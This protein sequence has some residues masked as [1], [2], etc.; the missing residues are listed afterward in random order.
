MSVSFQNNVVMMLFGLNNSNGKNNGEKEPLVTRSNDDN[1]DSRKKYICRSS[2]F[3]STESKGSIHEEFYGDLKSASK[4]GSQCSKAR[5][6]NIKSCENPFSTQGRSH[7]L[8]IT[9]SLRNIQGKISVEREN[10]LLLQRDLSANCEK[11]WYDAENLYLQMFS[12][13]GRLI[14]PHSYITFYICTLFGHN[15]QM[16]FHTSILSF[17][18]ELSVICCS[19]HLPPLSI[20]GVFD[21]KENICWIFFN[22]GQPNE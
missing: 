18:D 22:R 10:K 1:I 12:M 17:D 11:V 13:N 20:V 15:T 16:Y 4:Q 14:F 6:A 2:P 7:N 3:S 19:A 5:K 9:S 8:N 21:W